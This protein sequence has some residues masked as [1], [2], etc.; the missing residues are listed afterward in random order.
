M[1]IATN[2]EAILQIIDSEKANLI[3]VTK[4]RTI[5]ELKKVYDFGIK[6]F[7][8][9]RVQELIEKQPHFPGVE[10]HLIGHLQTNKVKYIAPFIHLIH[11]VDSFKLL[12]EINKQAEKNN[13]TIDCLLQMYIAQEETKFGLNLEELIEILNHPELNSLKNIRIIGLMGMASLTENE[14]QIND[15]FSSLKK[16]FDQLKKKEIN[17]PEIP[18]IEWRE[19]SMGMSSDYPIALINGSTLVRVGSAIFK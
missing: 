4:T 5:E 11:S 1:S 19:L 9:N 6:K 15:E 14:S 12:K 7:G 8:E 10:W 16:I 2:L 18:Q 17:Y 3:A 13:R